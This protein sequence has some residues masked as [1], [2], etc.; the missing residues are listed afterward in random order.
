MRWT[1]ERLDERMAAIDQRLDRIE[2]A[3]DGLRAEVVGLRSDFAAFQDRMIQVGFWFVGV[4]LVEVIAL[5][6]AL[7]R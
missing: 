2:V 6:V 3:V 1:D 7:A 5:V 4:L